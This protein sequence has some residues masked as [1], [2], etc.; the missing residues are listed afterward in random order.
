LRQLRLEDLDALFLAVE[1]CRQ[2]AIDDRLVA[3]WSPPVRRRRLPLQ[4]SGNADQ[5]TGDLIAFDQGKLR[6]PSPAE[7]CPPHPGRQ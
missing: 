2:A 7:G 4:R 5:R 6:I 3:G 1:Q